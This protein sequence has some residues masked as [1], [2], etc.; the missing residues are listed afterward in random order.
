MCGRLSEGFYKIQI[1]NA[2]LKNQSNYSQ[3]IFRV[4]FQFR[5]GIV[6]VKLIYFFLIEIRKETQFLYGFF[7]SKSVH[8]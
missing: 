6:P 8:T 2:H 3:P 1:A 4:I 5:I 7:V